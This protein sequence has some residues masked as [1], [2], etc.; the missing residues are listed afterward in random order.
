[1]G[2][3]RP[4]PVGSALLKGIYGGGHTGDIPS[5]GLLKR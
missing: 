4:D 2:G 3:P 5:A 1:M